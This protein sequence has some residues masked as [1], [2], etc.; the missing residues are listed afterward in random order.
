MLSMCKKAQSFNEYALVIALITLVGIGMQTYIK[1]GIQ[2]VIKGTADDLVTQSTTAPKIPVVLADG[3]IPESELHPTAKEYKEK[4][5]GSVEGIRSGN[6]ISY[7]SFTSSPDDKTMIGKEDTITHDY[8]EFGSDGFAIGVT[9]ETTDKKKSV[10][11]SDLKFTRNEDAKTYATISVT[12]KQDGKVIGTYG[13][14][15]MV[16]LS[17]S[18]AGEAAAQL[19]GIEEQGLY[20]FNQT[21]TV[22]SNKN[23]TVKQ[24]ALKATNISRY[25]A[26]GKDN[27]HPAFVTG[28]LSRFNNQKP[29]G[30]IIV[31]RKGND[32][33]YYYYPDSSDLTNKVII[34]GEDAITRIYTTFNS[35]GR[36]DATYN[37]LGDCIVQYYHIDGNGK[38]IWDKVYKDYQIIRLKSEPPPAEFALPVLPVESSGTREKT[39]NNDTTVISGSGEATYKLGTDIYKPKPKPK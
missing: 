24:Y 36:P 11:Y 27:W 39:I 34:G 8:T 12:V 2:G 5:G 22:T 15:E 37:Y 33:Y 32:V 1:R 26:D 14:Y 17:S 13:Q 23:I 3:R 21:I 4:N 10:P 29:P 6:T 30:F 35:D 28:Y 31:E 16:R 19:K 9:N 18:A 38:L 20:K 7:Y 25:R